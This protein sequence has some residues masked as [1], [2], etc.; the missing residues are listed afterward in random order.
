MDNATKLSNVVWIIVLLVCASCTRVPQEDQ[1][2]PSDESGSTDVNSNSTAKPDE[3]PAPTAGLSTPNTVSTDM[4][5]RSQQRSVGRFG[6]SEIDINSGDVRGVRP[7]ADGSSRYG[8]HESELSKEVRRLGIPI[9]DQREW[10][11]IGGASGLGGMHVDYIYSRWLRTTRVLLDLLDKVNAPDEERRAV[12]QRLMTSL[13][14]EKAPDAI[15]TVYALIV[16]VT[17]RH[18]KV[19]GIRR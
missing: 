18:A 2:P 9:P 1:G 12:L 4:K 10:V 13:R 16:E 14:T 17:D 7:T 11:P 5:A 3:S 8:I 15:D 6:G 19:S